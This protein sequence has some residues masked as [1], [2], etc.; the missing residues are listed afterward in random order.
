MITVIIQDIVSLF[1]LCFKFIDVVLK[2]SAI[3][4]FFL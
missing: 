1:V 3:L 2:G 4:F